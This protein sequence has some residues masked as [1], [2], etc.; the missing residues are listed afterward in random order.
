MSAVFQSSRNTQAGWQARL[1]LTF[2][3]SGSKTVLKKRERYGPL[4]VQRAFYPEKD[5]CHIYLLHPPGGVVGGDEL[6]INISLQENARAL[7][8]TPGATK[9]YRSAGQTAM[10]SQCFNVADHAVLEWLPQENIFFPGARLN[11]RLELNLQ[12]NAGAAVWEI[13]CLGRP[14]I[15]EV[16]DQGKLDNQWIIRRDGQPL[17]IERLRL[18]ASRLKMSAIMHDRA[19]VGTFIVTGI[20]EALLQN[21]RSLMFDKADESLAITNLNDLLVVR[22]LGHSTENA[23][24]LFAQVWSLLRP[25]VFAREAMTPRIWNT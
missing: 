13:Q 10:Q 6:D 14:V 9:F 2:S 7:L 16:F 22:Y 4:S 24:R 23:R 3:D 5:V 1:A 21:V 18:D 25:A 17:M 15:G 19:V 12:G 20:T 8:T 11:S